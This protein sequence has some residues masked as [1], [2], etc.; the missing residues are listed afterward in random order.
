MR[1][2]LF[3]LFILFCLM[4]CAGRSAPLASPAASAAPVP[5]E[6]L[7][8]S[9]TDSPTAT[10][11]PTA[12]SIRTP[13]ALPGV[14]QTALQNPVDP[15]HA[16]LSNACQYLQD[17]WSSKNSTPGTIVIPV[18]FHAIMAPGDTVGDNQ[19]SQAQFT[20][21][22]GGL[23]SRGFKGITTAQLAGFLEHNAEIP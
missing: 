5:T 17:K 13:P 2:T 14:F 4:G 18:M 16:Y 22:M 21:L 20:Q 10:P 8:L 3:P 11:I 15:P 7:T 23:E 19:I 6:T 1:Q 12:T 9:P